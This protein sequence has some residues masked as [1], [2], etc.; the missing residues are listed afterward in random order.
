MLMKKLLMYFAVF[1]MSWLSGTAAAEDYLMPQYGYDT[2]VV[3]KDAPIT[4]YDFKG[5]DTHFTQSAF[6][7]VIFKPATEGYSIKISFE[8]LNLTRYSASYDVY[9]RLY[10]GQYDVDGTTYP[11]SGNPSGRFAEN[12]NQI[13]Y[14]PG[15]GAVTPLPTYISGSADGCLSVCLYS[16][17]PSPKESYWKATVEEVLLES[18]T[19]KAAS[20]NNDFVDG[21]I[22]AGKQGVGVAGFGITTEGYSSPDKLQSLTFTCTNAAVIDA[23]AL[24]LYAGQSASVAG[25]T[26]VA[27]TITEL[28]EEMMSV[29]CPVAHVALHCLRHKTT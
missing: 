15:D 3:S 21:E 7:T 9:L 18:M 10:N 22:W 24:K 25:L 16:K 5:A 27:G 29:C 23:T 28:E 20:G 4:F 2:K 13:A 19:V 1:A 11:T 17:D 6:S 26:E 12:A 8:E 14:I